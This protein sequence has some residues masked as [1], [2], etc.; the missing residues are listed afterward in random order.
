MDRILLILLDI[1]RIVLK[2]MNFWVAK[3]YGNNGMFYGS[4]KS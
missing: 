2:F 3:M 1:S 4:T